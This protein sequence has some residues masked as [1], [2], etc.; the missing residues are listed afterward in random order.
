MAISLFPVVE[1]SCDQ[2]PR[3]PRRCCVHMTITSTCTSLSSTAAST[4]TTNALPSISDS[5]PP[6]P[7]S[8]AT[9]RCSSQSPY[10]G[11]CTEAQA[12][13]RFSAVRGDAGGLTA[14]PSAPLYPSAHRS[15]GTRAAPGSAL[16]RPPRPSSPRRSRRS[17]RSRAPYASAAHTAQPL[18]PAG[19]LE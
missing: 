17:H 8:A 5:L 11:D 10:H 4:V 2:D 15:P 19:R 18:T 1:C 3:C 12:R 13:P 6:P 9:A 7:L 14:P 16:R